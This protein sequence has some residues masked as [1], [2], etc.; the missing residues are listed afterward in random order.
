M[1]VRGSEGTRGVPPNNGMLGLSTLKY[2]TVLRAALRYFITK[3]LRAAQENNPTITLITLPCQVFILHLTSHRLT[4]LERAV[5][6]CYAARRSKTGENS[7]RLL[8]A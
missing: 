4:Q 8:V 6:V 5:A 1:P 2:L 3:A 7:K